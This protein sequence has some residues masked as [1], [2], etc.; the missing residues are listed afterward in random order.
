MVYHRCKQ[1]SAPLPQRLSWFLFSDLKKHTANCNLL[2]RRVLS[3][4]REFEPL[5]HLKDYWWKHLQC[6]R[7]NRI[8][9]TPTFLKRCSEEKLIFQLRFSVCSERVHPADRNEVFSGCKPVRG[10]PFHK[11]EHRHP[12]PAIR[13]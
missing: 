10:I 6:Q 3:Q 4:F 5:R 12:A 13:Q 2:L 11:P 1:Y 8:A 9:Q 7:L